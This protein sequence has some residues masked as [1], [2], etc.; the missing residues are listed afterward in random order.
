MAVLLCLRRNGS[1]IRKIMHKKPRTDFT[2][3]GTIQSSWFAKM[4]VHH[5]NVSATILI[6]VMTTFK[7]L[8]GK[9]NVSR[10][11]VNVLTSCIFQ[12]MVLKTLSAIANI[13]TRNM[14]WIRKLVVNVTVKDLGRV[15]PVLVG[16]NLGIIRQCTK[17]RSRRKRRGRRWVWRTAE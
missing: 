14:M 3:L 16:I 1:N 6:K 12:S 2:H 11:V 4:W 10:R 9:L 7:L 8:M 17:N 13:L 15:G 5:R